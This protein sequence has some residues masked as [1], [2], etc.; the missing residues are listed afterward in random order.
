MKGKNAMRSE[1]NE[2]LYLLS[3]TTTSLYFNFVFY[4]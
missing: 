3:F 4:V 1:I 2:T